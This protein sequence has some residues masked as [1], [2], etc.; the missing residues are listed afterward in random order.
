M[1]RRA[2]VASVASSAALTGCLHGD[3]ATDRRRIPPGFDARATL[4]GAPPAG[5][6]RLVDEDLE[7]VGDGRDTVRVERDG[8]T[9]ELGFEDWAD[10]VAAE[11]GRE[12]LSGILEEDLGLNRGSRV[13]PAYG[14]LTETVF[15]D[16]RGDPE[17]LRGYGLTE[18]SSTLLVQ[19]LVTVDPEGETVTTPPIAYDE[20]VRR[21]PRSLTVS[22]GFEGYEKGYSREYPVVVQRVAELV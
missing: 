22:L 5:V 6:E 13:I 4:G 17:E 1:R 19:Y 3:D 15:E 14:R 9:V 7:F 16:Y 21:V 2:F 11:T 12:D 18:S 8:E 20:V 10:G